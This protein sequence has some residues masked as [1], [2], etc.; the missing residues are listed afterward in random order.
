MWY[1]IKDVS[2]WL[3]EGEEHS[4]KKKQYVL[5]GSR[6]NP[7]NWKL[8]SGTT[9]DSEGLCTGIRGLGHQECVIWG[10]VES[11]SIPSLSWRAFQVDWMFSFTVL[12]FMPT[13]LHQ[14]FSWFQ[15]SGWH[16]HV[17]ELL[18]SPW[19]PVPMARELPS[20][21]LQKVLVPWLPWRYPNLLP[22]H[23][24]EPLPVLQW[25]CLPCPL[26]TVWR[27]QL[28]LTSSIFFLSVSG[29]PFQIS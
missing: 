7:R 4:R 26:I 6:V 21:W 2:T 18:F 8:P 13:P 23:F 25:G 9:E 3:R 19:P 16:L 14:K 1:N 17:S 27:Q 20:R 12:F 29:S 10:R 24:L 15:V 22:T 28:N 11:Q 5:G